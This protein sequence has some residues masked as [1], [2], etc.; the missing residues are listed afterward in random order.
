KEDLL[1]EPQETFSDGNNFFN[2]YESEEIEEVESFHTDEAM[3]NEEDLPITPLENKYSP[4]I[5][6]T[7]IEKVLT[8]EEKQVKEAT[9]ILKEFSKLFATGLDMLEY[10]TEVQYEIDT[11]DARP[12]KQAD[13]MDDGKKIP[14]AQTIEAEEVVEVVHTISEYYFPEEI[15]KEPN[16][17]DLPPKI[18]SVNV[19]Y[20]ELTKET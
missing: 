14:E 9:L 4:A 17:I 19:E 2:Q 11:R 20:N 13:T 15:E 18:R 8:F 6:L 1:V 5:Y 12:I 7:S 10:A 16:W 3:T